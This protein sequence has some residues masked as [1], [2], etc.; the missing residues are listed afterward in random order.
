MSQRV[1]QNQRLRVA[2]L[3]WRDAGH[4]EAGGAEVFLE[5]VS[6]ELAALGHQVTVCVSR[7][8]GA[9]PRELVGDVT[10][11]RLGG[12]LSVYP[13]VFAWL[14][15]HR[16]RFDV[17]IDV[18]N[19]LPFWT[20]ALGKPVVNVTHHL[21]REQWPEVFGPVRAHLGWWLES[22]LAPR[23]YRHCQYFTVS[24][25]TRQELALVGVDPARVSVGYSGLHDGGLPF[26]VDETREGTPTLV[27]LGRL[28]PHKRVELAIDAVANLRELFPGLRLNVV[29]GGYWQPALERHAR[30]MGVADLVTFT[31]V[32]DE[33]RKRELLARAWV[34]LLPSLKE[35]WGLV[36]VEAGI[37]GTPTV[38]FRSAG[39]TA[40]SVLHDQTGVLVDDP[41][42]FVAAV[43]G[44]LSDPKEARRLGRAAR[45]HAAQF[46][47]ASTA[48]S[49]E[50]VL[51]KAVGRTHGLSLVPELRAHN[52][53]GPLEAVP[54]DHGRAEQ[55]YVQRGGRQ[56]G[57]EP[58]EDT[59]DEAAVRDR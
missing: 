43:S 18:Q 51:Y 6:A 53:H 36:V 58:Q 9:L 27:V 15:R 32:V 19:G 20:P 23:I 57:S 37:H 49:V 48:T 22:R 42:Q 25:A 52:A 26:A 31:G 28:V 46:T 40:E 7:Y 24:A 1:E 56:V 38:A 55:G 16:A 5:R 14:L 4:P 41:A 21:H 44:L 30:H 47:W 11:V 33:A 45:T 3:N 50:A 54:L 39:G 59:L 12:R 34:N 8:A 13:R 10:Y 29:G 2:F 17:A 35:G